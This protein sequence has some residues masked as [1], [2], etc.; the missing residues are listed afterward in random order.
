MDSFNELDYKPMNSIL[1][2][3][4]VDNFYVFKNYKKLRLKF[5]YDFGSDYKNILYFLNDNLWLLLKQLK[6]K[7]TSS[8]LNHV[9]LNSFLF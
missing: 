6:I 8:K 9:L 7:R 5:S 3:N 2:T 1:P 4:M